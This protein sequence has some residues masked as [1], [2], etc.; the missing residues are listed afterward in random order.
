MP[1]ALKY[2][3][4]DGSGRPG[5]AKCATTRRLYIEKL[6]PQPQDD[7]ALGL[8]ITNFAP[9]SSSEKS[10]SAFARNGRLCLLYTSDAADDLQP[11]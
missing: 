10:I 1:V 3:S 6:V 4:I 9:I 8:L 11:V 7:E 2:L 5:A